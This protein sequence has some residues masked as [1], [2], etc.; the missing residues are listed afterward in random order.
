MTCV[1]TELATQI[2]FSHDG[3]AREIERV[4]PV[5][6]IDVRDRPRL[7]VKHGEFYHPRIA[8]NTAGTS[9][10]LSDAMRSKH[11]QLAT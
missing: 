9:T 7:N 2:P 1:V 10:A 11:P 8:R 3:P 6:G 4:I 5:T